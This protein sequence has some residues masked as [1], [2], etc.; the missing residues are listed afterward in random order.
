MRFIWTI[1][2]RITWANITKYGP[3]MDKICEI[4]IIIKQKFS[5]F[6]INLSIFQNRIFLIFQ[7]EIFSKI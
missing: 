4:W 7:I 5:V 6:G 3:N 1:N 2:G